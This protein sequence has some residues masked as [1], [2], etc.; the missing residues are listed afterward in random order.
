M[1]SRILFVSGRPDDARVLSQMLQGLPVILDYVADM[2]HARAKLG[3][4]EYQAILTEAALP[5]GHWLDM[6]HLTRELPTELQVVVTSPQADASMWAE[7]LNM[8]VYDVLA[9]PFYKPEVQRVMTNACSR[10]HRSGRA[11]AAV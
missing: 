11:M 10:Q 7:A 4:K 3:Q 9:Q 1:R 2:Q 6:L 8:G 5:D